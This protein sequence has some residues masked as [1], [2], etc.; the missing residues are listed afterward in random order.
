MTSKIQ[1][2][3]FVSYAHADGDTAVKDFVQ[4]LQ[5]YLKS[6]DR[7]WDK[8]DDKQIKVGED[9]DKTI[10]EALGQ[11]CNCCLLLLSDLFAKSSYIAEKE[12]PK[13]LERYKQDGIV[14]F[15]LVF[16]VLE[17]GIASLPDEMSDYQVYWP[18]VAELFKV[19]P[20]TVSEPEKVRLCY[21]EA[22][23]KPAPRQIFLSRLATQMNARF[24]E[25]LRAQAAKARPLVPANGA[26]CEDCVTQEAD[27]ETLAETLFGAFSYEKRY[28]HS[29]SRGRYFLRRSDDDLYRKLQDRAWVLVEGHPLAGKTR[30]V[31]E[32]IKRLRGEGKTF[33]VWPFKAPARADQ[34]LAMPDFSE[35]DFKI[36]WFD[37]IDAL[38]RRLVRMGC[39]AEDVNHFMGQLASAGVILLATARTGPANYDFR[40][41]FGLDDHIW[42]KLET[43][44]IPRLEGKEEIA[45]AQW[46]ASFGESLPDRFDHQ[47]GSLFIDLKAMQD[48]WDR[49]DETIREQKSGF[50]A[51]RAKDILRALHVFYL[52]EAWLPGGLFREEDIRYYLRRKAEKSETS[53]GLAGAFARAKAQTGGGKEADWHKLVEFLALDQDHLGFLRRMERDGAAWLQTET[54]YL[55][56]IV[57]PGADKN[58][59]Q[60]VTELLSLDERKQ[61]G[62]TVTAYNYGLVF[63]GKVPRNEKDLETLV[64]KLKPLGLER[65]IVVW[66][67]LLHLCPTMPLARKCLLMLKKAGLAPDVVTYTSLLKRVRALPEALAVLAE[68]RAAGLPPNDYSYTPV[69]KCARN[70]AELETLLAEMRRDGVAL[71]QH[72]LKTV[73]RILDAIPPR[74][75]C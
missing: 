4:G 57:A 62:L 6:P 75:H 26:S 14:F 71:N 35:A 42:D 15:P 69:L 45:F 31:F 41:R 55:D 48:R 24:D 74:E 33:T 67:Q 52:M 2:K 9:W 50:E 29:P 10:Q 60:A 23:E 53:G 21:L 49:M 36:A 7:K 47:P 73:E 16:G 72:H 12:W 32:A 34:P 61:L 13:T 30:A 65:E 18:T 1:P 19:P 68:M 59:V 37:D 63:Q 25:Y 8:W 54:A 27:E 38:F 40:H 20:D 66:N 22:K 56:H 17:G 3:F 39:T 70:A 51:E 28:Q 64:R 44:A 46:Y 11:G 58:I 5:E 43:L